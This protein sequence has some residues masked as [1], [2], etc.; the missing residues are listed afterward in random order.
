M[1]TVNGQE[2]NVAGQTVIDFLKQR[3]APIENIV[4]E[5]N[6]EIVHRSEFDK[7]TLASGDKVELISFV[8]GG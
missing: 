4:V 8:G 6:G 1:V 3:N 5:R 7:V 2:E